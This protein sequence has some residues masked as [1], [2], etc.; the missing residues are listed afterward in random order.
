MK[1]PKISIVFPNHNGGNEPLECLASIQKLNYPKGK[2]ETIIV[3]ND[4]R[5]GSPLRIKESFPSVK[6]IK[7][8]ANFGFAKA[9]NQGIAIAN[10]EFIFITNDDIVFEKESLKK[11]VKYLVSHDNVGIVG[12]KIYYKD[13]PEKIC[14]SGYMMN[15]WTGNIHPAPNPNKLKEPDWVQGCAIIISKKVLS[16]IG[17]LDPQYFLSFDD[18]DLCLRTKKFGL[19]VIYLPTAVFWHGES[20]TVDRNKP[21]KYYHWY[22]SK[23]R[24]VIKHMPILNALSILV[25]QL[26]IATPY[27]A[28][29]LRDGRF[30][31]FLKGFA[32]NL[33]NLRSTLKTRNIL[34]ASFATTYR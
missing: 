30:I 9:V 2:I 3:D 27:R 33:I 4:S 17:N 28:L 11:S 10:G 29:V 1:Y 22:K 21:F 20:L 15:K 12:G 24:F 31:P 8:R 25:F 7:N 5:D 18:Y 6:L 16:K 34:K 23:I 26:L 14:S 32:W 19:K 13:A